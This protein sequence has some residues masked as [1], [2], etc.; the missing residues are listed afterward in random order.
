MF[1]LSQLLAEIKTMHENNAEYEEKKASPVSRAVHGFEG[2]GLLLYLER[3][4]V[5]AVVLPVS[6]GLP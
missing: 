3:E 4:H 5:L 6:G 1:I 2:E